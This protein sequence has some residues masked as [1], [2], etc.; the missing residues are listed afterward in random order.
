MYLEDETGSIFLPSLKF[1]SSFVVCRKVV[2]Y[3][4]PPLLF[5]LGQVQ[6][7]RLNK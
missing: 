7:D 6:D 1:T 2:V 4:S 5:F 3:T